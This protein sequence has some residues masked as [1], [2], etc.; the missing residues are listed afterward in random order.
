MET[1]DVIILCGINLLSFIL[2]AKI[3]Q[4][5]IR[6]KEI[7]V[8]PIKVIKDEIRESKTVKED[9]LRK[10]QLETMLHNIDSYDGTGIG[11]KIIP[12]E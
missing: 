3:G 7:K 1:L 9:N 4:E 8:N 2:G 11:Q 10:R 12:K 6:G 5:S